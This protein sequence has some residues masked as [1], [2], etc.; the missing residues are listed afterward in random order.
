[1]SE[2]EICD[3]SA[4]G[5]MKSRQAKK[6]LDTTRLRPVCRGRDELKVLLRIV[7]VNRSLCGY[8]LEPD[9]EASTSDL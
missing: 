7:G 6:S 4:K 5:E 3:Q 9:H 8:H 2:E 1:M